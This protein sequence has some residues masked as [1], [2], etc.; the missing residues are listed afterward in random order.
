MAT[1]KRTQRRCACSGRSADGTACDRS[2]SAVFH[3]MRLGLIFVACDR[4]AARGLPYLAVVARFS[5]TSF[6]RTV[7]RGDEKFYCGQDC[8][9][10][11][12]VGKVERTKTIGDTSRS[13]EFYV[14]AVRSHF[15]KRTSGRGEATGRCVPI[16][17]ADLDGRQRSFVPGLERRT[18]GLGD[19]AWPV[20]FAGRAATPGR[21]V[22]D[23]VGLRRARG[24]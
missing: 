7:G 6:D 14:I 18:A 10:A 22:R 23:H 24:G 8:H 13:G 15:D 1:L 17:D 4:S 16:P 2:W 20:S 9:L 19:R 3:A 5:A 12:S 11:Y 21:M